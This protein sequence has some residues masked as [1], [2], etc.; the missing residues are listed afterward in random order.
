MSS[1]IQ[2]LRTLYYNLPLWL[3]SLTKL[4]GLSQNLPQEMIQ[5]S[6]NIGLYI[7][8]VVCQIGKIT[9]NW[10]SAFKFVHT[11]HRKLAFHRNRVFPM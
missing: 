2:N 3:A 8:S 10:A 11:Y 6:G 7:Y 4:D 9:F 1:H 5:F